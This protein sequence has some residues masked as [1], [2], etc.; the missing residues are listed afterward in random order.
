MLMGKFNLGNITH[1]NLFSK[2]LGFAAERTM[3]L[4]GLCAGR[5]DAILFNER[6][7]LSRL[8]LGKGGSLCGI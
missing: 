4:I 3:S 7:C 6:N 8:E 2:A 5:V 1:G